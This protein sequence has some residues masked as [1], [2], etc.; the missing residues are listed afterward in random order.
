MKTNCTLHLSLIA[1]SLS[2]LM[3]CSGDITSD[4]SN[5]PFAPS[6]GTPGAM[7]TQPGGSIGAPGDVTPGVAA[8]IDPITGL[9]TTPTEPGVATPGTSADPT[10]PGAPGT[11]AM[12]TT[13]VPGEPVDPTLDPALADPLPAESAGQLV[14]RRLNPVEYSNTLFDLLGDASSPGAQL[15]DEANHQS[16]YA[17]TESA[18]TVTV[19]HFLDTAERLVQ[20]NA[21]SIPCDGSGGEQACA[22]EFIDDFGRKAFRRPVKASERENLLVLFDRARELGFTVEE[23]LR[24]V[25]SAMLQSSGFLY[26]W[27]IDDSRPQMENGVLP[28]TQHQLASRLS[29]LITGSTPDDELSA[30]ADSSSLTT[31]DQIRAQAERLLGSNPERIEQALGEFHRQWLHIENLEDLV[32]DP[33]TY[34][35]FTDTL[36][37]GLAPELRRFSFEVL[38]NGEG[39][40]REL[41]TSTHT[42]AS[43]EAAAVYGSSAAGDGLTE[44]TFDPAQR[45]GILT[46]LAFLATNANTTGSNPPR[47]GKVLWEQVLCGQVPP[48]PADVPGVEPAGDAT[49][50]RQR[51]EAHSDNPCASACHGILDPA[52]FAFEQ[53]DGMGAFRAEEN[54]ITVDASGVLRTP[55]G[56]SLEFQNAVELMAQLAES[57]EVD[58]CVATQWFRFMLNR[59]ET[60]ADMGSLEVAYRASGAGP[61]TDFSVREFLLQMVQTRAFR[62]RAPTAG[63]PM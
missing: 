61:A 59:E 33:T 56:A 50:T 30:L 8:P 6:S 51:F 18:S 7:L 36:R 38:V 22:T 3:A 52:G 54:G 29:Y 40:T 28:L 13:P 35:D 42:Y 26:L 45:A 14:V 4:A 10:V 46:Q 41:L 19:Q 63:E 25:A 23:S 57:Y 20:G 48:P 55:G 9:P 27:E 11:T 2:G 32:K 34:P 58:R 5:D 60:E 24:H 39:T 12:P 62:Y 15:P 16:G 44:V 47:R 21:L 17:V 43:E 31:P 37:D 1:L 49:T 53:Y